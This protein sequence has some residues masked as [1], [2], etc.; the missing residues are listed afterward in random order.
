MLV[1]GELATAVRRVLMVSQNPSMA[2]GGGSDAVF[3]QELAL[4]EQRGHQILPF[5]ARQAVSSEL[6]DR[7]GDHFVDGA[8]LG[9]ASPLNAAKFIYSPS[10][11]RRVRRIINEFRPNIIHLHIYYGKITSSI[12]P[13]IRKWGGPVV[14][15]LHEYR[16]SCA[17]S[18]PILNGVVCGKCR[19]SSYLPALVNRCNKGS[20]ARS[21]LSVVEM[22]A[23]DILGSK[24]L[25][26][27]ICVSKAQMSYLKSKGLAEDKC[28]VIYNPVS[29]IFN[30]RNMQRDID[31]LYV[32]RIE[33]YKGVDHVLT[34]ARR[35]PDLRFVVIGGGGYLKR[36][37]ELAADCENL[38]LMGAS[39]REAV[40]EHMNRAKCVIVPSQWEETFGLISAEAMACGAPVVASNIGGIPEVV[41]DGRTGFLVPAQAVEAFEKAI[42]TLLADK[43]L[44][45]Q[46]S[47]AGL[48]AVATKF[49]E[50]AHVQALE[51]LY[52]ALIY[53]NSQSR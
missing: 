42:R 33:T 40:A 20:L 46:F 29:D 43:V 16:Y 41:T 37:R 45:K 8:D 38:L 48:E 7:F 11:A 9:S 23:G 18:V 13:E 22:Y 26:H 27:Y 19:K 34:L 3:L 17:V 32:G 36:F 30:L 49:S 35:N 21:A 39:S 1:E 5:C 24:D 4:L 52:G 10:S 15:T 53:E 47:V 28:S 50:T 2:S 44:W 25:D 31:V 51:S 14:Q 6:Q 12:L